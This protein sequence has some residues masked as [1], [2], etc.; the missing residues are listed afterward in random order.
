MRRRIIWAAIVVVALLAV[1]VTWG[2]LATA[3]SREPA[4]AGP[5]QSVP[6]TPTVWPTPTAGAT[7]TVVPT[8]PP[9]EVPID[10]PAEV[11]GSVIAEV[12]SVERFTSTGGTP[13]ELGGPALR[14]TVKVTN[15][16][17]SPADLSGASVTTAFGKDAVPGSELGGD[18]TSTLPASIQPGK[19]ASATYAF[20]IPGEQDTIRVTLDLLQG[21]PVVVFEGKI[22]GS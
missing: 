22:A 8:A 12:T 9:S 7:E 20:V 21:E 6:P 11:G 15:N 17:S 16:G 14:I 19:S 13:G 2:V 3:S 10:E 1:G 18:G 5:T 4:N